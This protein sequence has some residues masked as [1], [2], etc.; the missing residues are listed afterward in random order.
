MSSQPCISLDDVVLPVIP[1][2]I[3]I[4]LELDLSD[5]VEPIRPSPGSEQ[6]EVQYRVR[7]L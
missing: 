4:V 3:C 1:K 7:A 5:I 6:N 2:V